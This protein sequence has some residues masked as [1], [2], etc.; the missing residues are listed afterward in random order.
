[1]KPMQWGVWIIKNII[2][3]TFFN[4]HIIGII[5]PVDSVL[6]EVD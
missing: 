2:N 4:F 6:N 1:M 3:T 5:Q